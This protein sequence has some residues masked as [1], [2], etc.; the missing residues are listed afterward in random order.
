MKRFIINVLIILG[1]FLLQTT[2]FQRLALADAVPN[3]LL[4][5]TAA[6]GYMRGQTEGLLVGFFCGLLMDSYGGVIGIQA[7][8]YMLVGY[9]M[10]ICNMI[11][12]IDNITVP[13][14]LIGL[15]DF[16]YNLCFY[17]VSFLLRGRLNFLFYL[18]HVILPE[19]VYTVL[20]SVLL[21]KLLHV[22][23]EKIEEKESKEA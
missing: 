2:A 7:L 13:V 14:L 16:L 10:G 19:L 6:I 23:N 8:L 22:F 15:F 11:F 20:L 1:C 17:I 9:F 18:G 5:I 21:Y 4:I 3:L 12:Y